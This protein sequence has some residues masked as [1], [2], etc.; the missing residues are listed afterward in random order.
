MFDLRVKYHLENYQ[1]SFKY[2]SELI[3]MLWLWVMTKYVF[4]VF[5]HNDTWFGQKLPKLGLLN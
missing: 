1:K 2:S 5:A 4:R 3:W